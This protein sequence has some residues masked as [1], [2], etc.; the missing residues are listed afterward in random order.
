MCVTSKFSSGPSDCLTAWLHA[1]AKEALSCA[2]AGVKRARIIRKERC[3][4]KTE[5]PVM[6]LR[7]DK[8]FIYENAVSNIRWGRRCPSALW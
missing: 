6:A 5:R 1:P 8:D 3:P 2:V 7:S 4:A